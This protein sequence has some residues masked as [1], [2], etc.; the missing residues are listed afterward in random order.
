MHILIL[1]VGVQRALTDISYNNVRSPFCF[2]RVVK[3]CAFLAFVPRS[4]AYPPRDI[5]EGRGPVRAPRPTGSPLALGPGMELL[6]EIVAQEAAAGA[7]PGA[8][9]P[10]SSQHQPSGPWSVAQALVH[11]GPVVP[12]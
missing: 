10:S 1:E 4:A 12:L 8:V 3:H 5:A 6:D 2:I 11:V 7:W 9:A